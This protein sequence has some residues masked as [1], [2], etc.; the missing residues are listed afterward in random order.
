MKIDKDFLIRYST[1]RDHTCILISYKSS[2]IIKYII[3]YK[4]TVWTINIKR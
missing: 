3:L 2:V 1:V 4:A